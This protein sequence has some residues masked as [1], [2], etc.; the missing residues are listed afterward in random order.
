M[1]EVDVTNS[2]KLAK[3]ENITVES[4]YNIYDIFGLEDLPKILLKKV[5]ERPKKA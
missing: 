4:P 3:M 5:V 1:R 2:K